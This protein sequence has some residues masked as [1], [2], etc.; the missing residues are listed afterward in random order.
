MMGAECI[1]F[2]AIMAAALCLLCF[3]SYRSW[4]SGILLHVIRRSRD[5]F[6][7]L[8]DLSPYGIA[9]TAKDG[10][11]ISANM[12][13]AQ[14]LEMDVRQLVGAS[15]PGMLGLDI[16][17]ISRRAVALRPGQ[18]LRLPGL[19]VKGKGNVVRHIRPC[20]FS[21]ENDKELFF[22]HI[23]DQTT[24]FQL[25]KRFEELVESVP[26]G[27]F[28]AETDGIINAVNQE[29]LHILKTSKRP[30]SLEKILS[31]SQWQEAKKILKGNGDNYS[32]HVEKQLNGQCKHL[33]IQIRYCAYGG[34]A[35]LAGIVEDITLEIRLKQ[36][37]EDACRKA[38]AASQAKGT[39]LSNMSH[40]LRTPLNVILGMATIL[41][42]KITDKEA[43]N[44]VADLKKASEHIT[45]LIGDIL[46]L[47]KIESGKLTL[48]EEAF[49]LKELMDGLEA[50]LGVQARLKDLDFTIRFPKKMHR[51]YKGDPVRIRQIIFNLASN[52]LKFTQKGFI[53]VEITDRGKETGHKR[54]LAIRVRDT[55]PGIPKDVLSTLFDPFVQAEQ[56]RKVGGT[57]LGLSIAQELVAMMDG[58]ISVESE[59]GKGTEFLVEIGLEPVDEGLIKEKRPKDLKDLKPGKVLIADDA[60]M[61]R[62]ILRVFLERRGWKIF[63]AENGRQVLNIL[64]T[65]TDIDL[66][67]MDISMPE[68]DGIEAARQ[69]KGDERLRHIPIIAVTAHAMSDDRKR[70]LQAGMEG[71]VSKPVRIESLMEEIA[72]VNVSKG[73]K[74]KKNQVQN[75][76]DTRNYSQCAKKDSSEKIRSLQIPDTLP[77]DFKALLKTCQ[78]M[79]DLAKDL[80]LS[81]LEE[82][83]KWLKQA[84]KAVSA[85]DP[86]EIRKICHLIRGSASTVHANALHDAAERLGKASRE[87]K[88][89]IYEELFSSLCKRAKELE[90]WVRANFSIPKA[91]DKLEDTAFQVSSSKDIK[92]TA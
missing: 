37:L 16:A 25:E 21:D 22:W 68:M 82:S 20:L 87:G 13:L 8:V 41:E 61:N 51:Y 38:E 71:Y 27:L 63:E 36:Q 7:A 74:G 83:P 77:V 62:K 69:I 64:E 28:W 67:L 57:G 30:E 54:Q 49:D 6:K 72:Q 86:K 39:F 60:P 23:Q 91:L 59:L 17:D 56:G 48:E 42:D 50:V 89:E 43:L 11:I 78:G 85:K 75:R 24:Y 33:R 47:A 65:N 9:L 14:L 31:H 12:A 3:I 5:R 92:L 81:M 52:S 10:I 19:D 35:Y 2:Y 53:E 26:V 18:V 1:Y 29:F 46:D 44:L 15:L 4:K 32:I 88:E 66:I 80:L 79:E 58:S 73:F 55:G 34:S 40:E 90:I 70:F 76:A 84:E 45:S